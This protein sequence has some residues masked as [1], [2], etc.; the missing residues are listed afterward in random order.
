[1]FDLEDI[2]YFLFLEWLE[3]KHP[4]LRMLLLNLVYPLVVS[5]ITSLL[6]IKLLT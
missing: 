1:M 6:T 5:V 4:I 3:E 2:F